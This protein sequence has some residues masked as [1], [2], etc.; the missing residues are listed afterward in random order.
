MFTLIDVQFITKY[1]SDG[2]LLLISK[3]KTKAT[4]LND[5]LSRTCYYF[6]RYKSNKADKH[7]E[8]KQFRF[9]KKSH[10]TGARLLFYFLFQLTEK[11]IFP[12]LTQP[13]Q[14][15]N[16]SFEEKKLIKNTFPFIILW[17]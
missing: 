7:E 16:F 6:F 9:E 8:K 17:G 3:N 4:N 15:P 1:S 5:T 14:Q 10:K 2:F 12:S 13:Q 11:S